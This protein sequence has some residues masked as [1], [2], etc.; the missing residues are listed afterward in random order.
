MAALLVLLLLLPFTSY[1]V[2]YSFILFIYGAESCAHVRNA[3]PPSMWP[4]LT[5]SS[6]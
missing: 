2:I 6:L 3:V 4:G 1:V 5:V